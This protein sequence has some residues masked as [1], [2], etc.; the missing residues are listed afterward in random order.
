MLYE[1]RMAKRS[2]SL[3][4]RVSPALPEEVRPALALVLSELNDAQQGHVIDSLM[5][6]RDERMQP[7]EALHVLRESKR[8]VSGGVKAAVW[9]QPQ[10]GHAAALWLPQFAEPRRQQDDREGAH[11]LIRAAM[12]VS[13]QR[14]VLLSQALVA[15]ENWSAG[16]MLQATGF[17][18]I[19][20]LRYLT[21]TISEYEPQMAKHA[22][23]TQAYD[24][25]Q[26]ERLAKL[27]EATYRDTLDC[28]GFEKLRPVDDVITGYEKSGV[29]DPSLWFFLTVD[30]QDVGVLLLNKPIGTTQLELTYMGI[31]PEARG[32][33][34]GRVAI[35]LAAD[36]AKERGVE[37]LL[38]AVDAANPPA[39]RLYEEAGFFEW[40]RRVAY[41]RSRPK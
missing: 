1:Q 28:P 22:L 2:Q 37:E 23:G 12:A 36:R 14:G 3:S 10:A 18:A 38:L 40:A 41:I 32:R 39:A 27:L 19:A 30:Q 33:G 5:Q 25:Q 34:Y 35:Q 15:P 26:R 11:D 4:A 7:F 9:N 21:L 8:G 31:V 6:T 29:R 20:E 13:D 17:H 24:S 16:E